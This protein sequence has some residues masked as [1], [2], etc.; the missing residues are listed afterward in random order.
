MREGVRTSAEHI[1]ATWL[2]LGRQSPRFAE[3]AA[4][5][6]RASQAAHIAA[7]S[8]MEKWSGADF[9][10]HIRAP[11]LVVWGACDRSYLFSQTE[12]LWREIAGADLAVIPG[13]AHMA[14]LDKPALFNLILGDF[15]FAIAR[16]A[17]K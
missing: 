11:T 2:L 13:A 9:L 15:L 16:N 3:V 7:L 17:A 5:A 6:H 4:I 8:A 10:A 1:A 12:K 14:H